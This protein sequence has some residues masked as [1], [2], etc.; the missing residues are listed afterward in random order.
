MSSYSMSTHVLPAI[1]KK[2]WNHAYE[3][4]PTTMKLIE[5]GETLSGGTA[6]DPNR[7]YG[8]DGTS[9]WFSGSSLAA[10]ISSASQDTKLKKASY[11]WTNVIT[12][13]TLTYDDK[14]KAGD[15]E[16]VRINSL[17]VKKYQAT[18]EHMTALA[19]QVMQGTGSGNTPYGLQVY[20][21][22]SSTFGGVDPATD[23]DWV[24]KTTTSATTLTGQAQLHEEYLDAYRDGLW[25]D[26]G[27][28]TDALFVRVCAVLG[29]GIQYKEK[30]SRNYQ[31]GIEGIKF[32]KLTIYPDRD[33]PASNLWMLNS[34]VIHLFK[35]SKYFMK[36]KTPAEPT[37]GANIWVSDFGYVL[38]SFVLAADERWCASGWTSLS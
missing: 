17:E 21:T 11:G 24:P 8:Q 27:P 5:K 36:T 2:F 20:V 18:E 34:S 37:D 9:T 28:T 14:L 13:I 19:T 30:D 35:S 23:T 15:S 29:T 4:H 25:P 33:M 38:S 32:N 31:F 26:L 7:V 12:P 6:Y 10:A 3:E 22:P 16:Y 1:P